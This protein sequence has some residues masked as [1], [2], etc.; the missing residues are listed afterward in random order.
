MRGIIEREVRPGRDVAARAQ[1][2]EYIR[3]T[4]HTCWHPVGTCRM[5]TDEEAV[6]DPSLRVR[7]IIGLRV[8][9]ASVM[10]CLPSSNTNIPTIMLAERAADLI[11][12]GASAARSEQSPPG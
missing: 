7:G 4:G 11:R 1:L 3:A 8:V 10:P 2:L 9:D 12:T 5:G 6:V